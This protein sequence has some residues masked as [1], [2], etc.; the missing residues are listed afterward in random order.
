M[1]TSGS[2]GVPKG[3]GITHANIAWFTSARAWQPGHERVLLHS[4][5]AFDLSTYEMWVPLLTGGTVV[6]AP[7][8]N[9]DGVV[10]A[11]MIDDFG[12]S[13]LWLTAS[14]F[15][16]IARESP[17][18]FTGLTEVWTG[19]EAV[20]ATAVRRVHQACPDVQI[21]DGYGPTET[22]TFASTYPVAVSALDPQA[23]TLPIGTALDGSRL[24]VLDHRLDLV[25]AG[26]VGELYVAGGGVARGYAGQAGLTAERF[27]A[28]PFAGRARPTGP[29]T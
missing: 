8:G 24:Y 4:S 28:D 11:R 23:T 6:V 10:L 21:V 14:L 26:V 18:A 17:S 9:V 2:T 19:G 20:D 15:W 3:V 29:A 27:V 5:P 25:P 16:L 22:T 7:R 12:L 1:F 13:A